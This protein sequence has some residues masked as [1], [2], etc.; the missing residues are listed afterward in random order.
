M[1]LTKVGDFKNI[2]N[3][4]I[5][6]EKPHALRPSNEQFVPTITD[7]LFDLAS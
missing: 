5:S 6:A 7:N 4:F 1:G 3:P 2:G